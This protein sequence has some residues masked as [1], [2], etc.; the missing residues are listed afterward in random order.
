MDLA[1]KHCNLLPWNVLP[2]PGYEASRILHGCT[3]DDVEQLLDGTLL[4]EQLLWP[5]ILH[6]RHVQRCLEH[7]S[8]PA[9][10]EA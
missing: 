2:I 5:H 10:E 8:R 4:G 1:I 3:V 9:E 7:I 6:S